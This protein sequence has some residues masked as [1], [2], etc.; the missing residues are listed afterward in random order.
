MQGGYALASHVYGIDMSDSDFKVQSKTRRHKRTLTAGFVLE[1]YMESM[2][3]GT[4][5]FQHENVQVPV[6]RRQ[7]ASLR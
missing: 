2:R 6:G 7:L 3:F 1:S 4:E 5:S